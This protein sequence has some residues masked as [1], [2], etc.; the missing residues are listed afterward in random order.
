MAK[1][2]TTPDHDPLDAILT[3]LR[4]GGPRTAGKLAEYMNIPYSTLSPRLRQLKDDGRAEAVRDPEARVLTWHATDATIAGADD[5][6]TDIAPDATATDDLLVDDDSTDTDTE[7]ADE[8][9]AG[10]DADSTDDE[11]TEADARDTLIAT[12]EDEPT[13]EPSEPDAEAITDSTGDQPADAAATGTTA[14]TEAAPGASQPTGT[15]ANT[16][17]GHGAIPAA[18][19]A[20]TR[21]NPDTTYKVSQLSKALDGASAGAVANAA[22]KLVNHGELVLVTERPATFQAA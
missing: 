19:L 17:R 22:H 11:A 6:D 18:I 3:A 14:E 15:E 5:T 1:T 13:V 10:D 7:P 21:A 4:D 8:T 16:R 20:L 12:A 2:R 9:T